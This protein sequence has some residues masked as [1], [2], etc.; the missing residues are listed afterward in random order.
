[1][2][3]IARRTLLGLLLV[4]AG[5]GLTS[6][7]DDPAAP[8]PP[9]A[10]LHEALARA[11]EEH[12]IPGLGAVVIRTGGSGGATALAVAGLRRLGAPDS[13]QA[14][15]LW[16][17]GS[18]TKAITATLL[19]VLVERD[20]LAWDSRVLEV[21]PELAPAAP[22][23]Y[24]AITLA[25]LLCHRAGI[26]SF[27][28]LADFLALPP[29]T[30]TNAEQR[31][32]F[33]A[34]L[35]ARPPETPPGQYNY[36][37]AGYAIAAAMAERVTGSGWE[38]LVQALVLAPLGVDGAFGWPGRAGPDQPWG[39]EWD[40][41]ALTPHD[42]W[43]EYALPVLI[44]PAGDVSLDLAGYG[45]F[46]RL[47]LAGLRGADGLLAAA[48]IQRLHQPVGDYALGWGIGSRDGD[49]ISAHFGSAG[50]FLCGAVIC[51]ERDLAFAVI[52][53][54]AHPA[55]EAGIAEVMDWIW[56]RAA[57]EGAIF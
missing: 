53:N 24:A 17:L 42:P 52:A 13:V 4:A 57:S 20:S 56:E 45:A 55:A 51:A 18:N 49:P 12:G 25:D 37:N 6:C 32:A 7:S 48:T 43:S 46:L 50:T 15:D 14:A 44:A 40:G 1:M 11:C 2:E 41:R 31:Y 23:E 27:E 10:N 3:S 30:G 39:H 54:A 19:G 33:T 36:S 29:F 35:L 38:E 28:E 34:W 22:A 16:H 21:F 26:P 9:P 8:P 5:L 47:H